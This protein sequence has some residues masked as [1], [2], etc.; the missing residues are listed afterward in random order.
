[1][2]QTSANMDIDRIL[3]K[4]RAE[5]YVQSSQSTAI[6]PEEADVAAQLTSES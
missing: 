6:T 1:M 3:D 4:I 5:F 2:Q